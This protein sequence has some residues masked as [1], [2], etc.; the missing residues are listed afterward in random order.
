MQKLTGISLLRKKAILFMAV[1]LYCL[2]LSGYGLLW[3]VRGFRASTKKKVKMGFWRLCYLPISNSD[4]T[5]LLTS[6]KCNSVCTFVCLLSSRC[7]GTY[8]I[9]SVPVLPTATFTSAFAETNTFPPCHD[10]GL[11]CLPCTVHRQQYNVVSIYVTPAVVTVKC[12]SHV[13]IA[14]R[15]FRLQI[16]LT[17]RTHNKIMEI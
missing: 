16:S 5:Y 10:L 6:F 3:K 1:T 13:L 11:H 14:S 15:N 2:N 9:D 4:I 8:P 17:E 7:H 12:I